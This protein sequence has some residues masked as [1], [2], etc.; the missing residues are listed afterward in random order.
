MS[1]LQAK[2]VLV[3]FDFSERCV[4]AV[5]RALSLIPGDGEVLVAHVMIDLHP[6]HPAELFPDFDPDV[7]RQRA[8]K[9]MQEM[10]LEGDVNLGNLKFEFAIGDAGTEIAELAKERN[11]NLV[12]VPSHGR[13]GFKR[14]VLGSVAERI[15]RLAPCPVL[16]VKE[17]KDYA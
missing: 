8:E 17:E 3:P 12:V 13:R 4:Q 11:V 14:M 2:K 16:I 15:A 10:L 6:V 7:E 1:G 9:K 5:R